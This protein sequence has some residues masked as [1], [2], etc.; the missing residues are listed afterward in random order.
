[1]IE[2]QHAALILIDM[3]HGFIDADSGL[4]I[5]GAAGTVPDCAAAL[6][7]ARA[8]G[9]RIYHAHR[10]YAADGSTVE[11]SRYQAWHDGGKPL[12]SEWP[13]SLLPPKELAPAPSET[14]F[15]KSRFSAFFGTKLDED[16]RDHS[17][18]TVVMAGTTTA[19]CVRA[20]CLDGLS[21]DYNVI[22]L[23]DAT[24]SPTPEVQESNIRDMANIGAQVITVDEFR[25][26]GLDNVIDYEEQLIEKLNA[27]NTPKPIER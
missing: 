4:Y 15:R 3:Q 26:N 22:V 27:N 13:E 8:L 18:T 20:T 7:R 5:A 6:N 23:S 25:E 24:S 9:M 16:L 11:A 1:V 12:S 2:P 17:I 14:V 19:N 21:L 10:E